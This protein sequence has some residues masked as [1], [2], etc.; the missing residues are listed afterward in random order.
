MMNIEE[1]TKNI[2]AEF[3][4]IEPGTITPT[5]NYRDIKGWSSMYALI[6]IAFVDTH[7]DVSL[8]A[9]DLKT[10]QTIQDL[11]KIVLEKTQA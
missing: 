4:D 5:T 3:E 7:F 8:S 6:I 2:E 9:D 11:Y 10:S 1:F